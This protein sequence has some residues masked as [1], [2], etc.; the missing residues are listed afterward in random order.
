MNDKKVEA[1]RSW[2]VPI[3]IKEIRGFLGFTNFYRHFIERF[4]RLAT[5]FIKLIKKD[6]IFE[7]IE[8]QQ[9]IF[10]DI[11]YRILN[12]PILMIADLEKPFKIETNALDFVFRG[13]LVQR[14]I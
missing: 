9:T 2:P 11:K 6:K 3:N 5:S 12:K 13:Q 7:W 1:I 10:D 8:Q 4:G 14:D